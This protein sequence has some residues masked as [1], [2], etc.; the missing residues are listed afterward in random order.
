MLNVRLR[1]DAYQQAEQGVEVKSLDEVVCG[2]LAFFDNE[3]GRITH[4]GIILNKEE[5]I[6]SSGKVRI[7]K[8]DN[9]GITNVD[10]GARTHK[11]KLIKRFV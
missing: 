7:D 1:R 4:V 3:E 5:I 9:D 6:H 8:L 10:T 2:D 11:L